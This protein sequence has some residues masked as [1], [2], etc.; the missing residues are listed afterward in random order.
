MASIKHHTLAEVKKLILKGFL[1]ISLERLSQDQADLI[2]RVMH[3]LTV[4]FSP[5][6]TV[7]DQDYY[8]ALT[9]INNAPKRTTAQESQ[10]SG[11]QFDKTEISLVPQG[12][13]QLPASEKNDP[14][15][16]KI[17]R[18]L[19]SMAMGNLGDWK[20]LAVSLEPEDIIVYSFLRNA[21]N[22]AKSAESFSFEQLPTKRSMSRFWNDGVD[23]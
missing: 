5:Q 23:L 22:R 12:L 4:N 11:S 14:I 7:E 19:Q 21:L 20:K 13:A 3:S 17:T 10:K 6:D 1:E 8:D 15:C 2:L 18:V 9:I 16:Q